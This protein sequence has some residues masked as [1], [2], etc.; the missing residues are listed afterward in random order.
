MSTLSDPSLEVQHDPR[1]PHLDRTAPRWDWRQPRSHCRGITWQQDDSHP[2]GLVAAIDD[3]EHFV[4][5]FPTA[6]PTH[7][8]ALL[9]LL[10]IRQNTEDPLWMEFHRADLRALDEHDKAMDRESHEHEGGG[11]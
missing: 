7:V 1:Q 6:K 5:S 11:Y 3:V 10:S 4:E 8:G 9:A 2:S